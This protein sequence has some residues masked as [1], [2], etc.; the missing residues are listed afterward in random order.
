M[1]DTLEASE[2]LV[3]GDQFLPR[4]PYVGPRP[5]ER[6]ERELLFARDQDARDMISL[7]IANQAFIIYSQSGA[8]KSSLINTRVID[9]LERHKLAIFPP[10][11]VQGKIPAFVD[12][13]D[14]DN[15]FTLNT[16]LSLEADA[17]PALIREFGRMSVVDYISR[18]RKLGKF[19]NDQPVVVVLDQFEE[20][21]AFYEHRW[22]DREKF[23]Q[24]LITALHSIDDLHVVFAMR[25]DYIANF[26]T[27]ARFFPN[28]LR[29]RYR[30]ERLRRDGAI[31][32]IE[33]PA[34]RAGRVF[35]PGLAERIAHDLLQTRAREISGRMISAEGEFI[36]AVQLQ[37]VCH[38]LWQSVPPRER[39]ITAEHLARFGSV[40]EVLRNFY[41]GTISDA[42]RVGLAV[43]LSLEQPGR[44]FSSYL[45]FFK[46]AAARLII[47]LAPLV[48][49]RRISEFF[50]R[51]WFNS[52]LITPAGTRGTVFRGDHETAGMP[53][54]LVE[55]F[56]NRYLIRGDWRAGAQWYEIT[57]DRL[58]RPI[59]DSNRAWF[60][61]TRRW[62]VT[63][64]ATA[65]IVG[66]L[67]GVVQIRE[68]QRALAAQ[69]LSTVLANDSTRLRF[70]QLDRSMLLS[71]WA[72]QTDN[73]ALTR[74]NLLRQVQRADRL[75]R[76][77][78]VASGDI[79]AATMVPGTN[80]IATLA[81]DGALRTWDYQT[82]E[83]KTLDA[84]AGP[85]ANVL[86]ADAGNLY[87][88]GSGAAVRVVGIPGLELPSDPGSTPALIT[89]RIRSAVTG[90]QTLSSADTKQGISSP[91][92]D[93]PAATFA[94]AN[95]RLAA[96]KGGSLQIIDVKSGVVTTLAVKAPETS[97][98]KQSSPAEADIKITNLGLSS[99]GKFV[100][101]V[102]CRF[103]H[104]GE[105]GKSPAAPP[106]QAAGPPQPA[107]ECG[108][109]FSRI[110]EIDGKRDLG[111]ESFFLSTV[112]SMAIAHD[113]DRLSVA[114]SQDDG[115]G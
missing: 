87:V 13:R 63:I 19:G 85:G 8:G 97:S 7:I 79:R 32:A 28:R 15:V 51:R 66:L 77:G 98:S 38:G 73:T 56:A 37:V 75:L 64:A 45:R 99:D 78:R 31:E 44:A 89:A 90:D 82:G 43:D 46:I 61:R 69:Q 42:T 104:T 106:Q 5:F 26:D 95:G 53:N 6:N 12:E 40:D 39:T 105:A 114:I 107:P 16:I 20:F 33:G 88:V 58:L 113:G 91:D 36:E 21:F 76:F 50:I 108:T 83:T 22:Q 71:V 4:N 3:P 29:A 48:V 86:L 23:V 25:E 24:Q 100:F 18:G 47:A 62:P 52:D 11:R 57:H 96:S 84:G 112:R 34:K 55:Y 81:G 10:V 60:K 1:N 68:K 27:Y 41:D 2:T 115:R 14:V 94:L 65:I 67:A 54:A 93:S 109:Y 110:W 9:G 80:L 72:Y 49:R 103:I 101:A 92:R 102:G 30:L 70:S 35:S 74:G 59:K 17:S 111:S